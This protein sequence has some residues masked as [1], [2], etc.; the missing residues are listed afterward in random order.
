M[1]EAIEL[2]E[3]AQ[4]CT[5]AVTCGEF[6]AVIMCGV[7]QASFFLL[8]EA[9]QSAKSLLHEADPLTVVYSRAFYDIIDTRIAGR[10]E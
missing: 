9:I 2:V 3:R 6:Y 5:A 1:T 7:Q 10:R 8:G 4:G